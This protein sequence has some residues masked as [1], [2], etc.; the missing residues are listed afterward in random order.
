VSSRWVRF[1]LTRALCRITRLPG[2]P[3]TALRCV[4]VRLT[5]RW[6]FRTN[7]SRRRS[8][9]N[10]IRLSY[11]TN[12]RW[13]SLSRWFVRAVRWSTI[14]TVSRVTRAARISTSIRS[15][16]RRSRPVWVRLSCSIR[17][18]W[19]VI[20]KFAPLSNWRTWWSDWRSPFRSVPG[21][22]CLRMRR[23]SITVRRL[24]ARCV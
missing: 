19:A 10:S 17:W 14:P 23:L 3:L 16:L 8:L 7:V 21:R 20:W 11:W 9:T 24:F 4:A 1:W 2:C 15:T 22:C 5:L 18:F 6:F 13:I 12:S